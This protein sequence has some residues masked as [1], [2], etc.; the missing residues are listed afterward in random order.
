MPR[1][2]EVKAR[3]RDLGQLRAR[4]EALTKRPCR[5]LNEHDTFFRVPQ[6][7]L[8]LRTLAHGQGELLWYQREDTRGPRAAHYLAA[9]TDEP[10]ALRELLSRCLGVA[11]T[12]TKRRSLYTLGRARVHLDEVAEL[13][14]FVEI[15]VAL[16]NEQT[17]DDGVEVLARLMEKLGISE[18]DLVA[19]AYVDLLTGN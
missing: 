13:G 16:A 12:V 17:A 19:G 6:G 3:V 18:D 10:A 5:V 14:S 11:G 1:S 9:T 15:E 8:K 2:V 7:R 4:A